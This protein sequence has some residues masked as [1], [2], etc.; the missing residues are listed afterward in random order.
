MIASTLLVTIGGLLIDKGL[1]FLKDL[2]VNLS[3]EGIS[4]IAEHLV[5]VTGVDIRNEKALAALTPEQAA[6][7]KE[8]ALNQFQALLEIKLKF[9]QLSN[10]ATA[11]ARRMNILFA[12]ER[13]FWSIITVANVIGFIW[14]IF[15]VIMLPSLVFLKIPTENIRFADTI[16]GFILGTVVSTIIN[17]YFGGSVQ[18]HKNIT[19]HV[20]ATQQPTGQTS[21]QESSP[22]LSAKQ[23]FR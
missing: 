15:S 1:G 14:T 19:Q 13:S 3:K 4:E 22:K 20:A 10:E 7:F 6:E 12:K 17:F 21:F 18:D 5:A 23:A 16:L 9:T 2:L 8:K 11:D